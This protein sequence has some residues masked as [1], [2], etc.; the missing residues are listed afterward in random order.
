[1]SGMPAATPLPKT[2]DLASFFPV[3]D[4]PEYRAFKSALAAEIAGVLA[5]A[6]ALDPLPADAAAGEPATAALLR[7]WGGVFAAGEELGSRAA[8]LFCYVGC[9]GAA[10]AADEAVQAEEAA[11][12]LLGAEMGKLG[13]QLLRGL[14][15]AGDAVFARLGAEPA[16]AGAA[17][18]LERLRAEATY[19]MAPAEEALAADLG[20][21]GFRA[22]GRLYDTIS[23]KMTFELAHADGRRETVP[24]AQ[25]RALMAGADRAVRRAAFEGAARTWA[26]AADTCAA[27]LN[28]IAGTRHT[29]Y[30]RRGRRHFL[31]AP[32]HDA[33]VSSGTLDAMFAAVADNY[34]LPRRVLELGARLQG[35]PALAW[36]DL[37]APRPLDPVPTLTWEEGVELVQSAFDAAYPRL[38]NYFRSIVRRR[39]IESEKRPNKR[40]GAFLT[41]SP[42]TL[43]ERIYMTFGGAMHDVVTLA[44]EA[45]HAWHT[46]LLGSLRPCAREYP[47]TLAETAST[48]A[49]KIFIDGLLSRANL[50]DTQRAYLLDTTTNQMPAYLL[51][52]PV[53][54]I[55]ERR[56]YEER[57]AGVVS[58]TRLSELMSAAQREVYGPTL[59]PGGEDPLFWASKLHFSMT[60]ISFYNFP[61]T[62]GFLLS[63]ALF[64]AFGREGP[65]F[66]PRYEAFLLRTGRATC[67]DAVRQTLGW[68]IR[69]AGFWAGAI[70]AGNGSVDAFAAVVSARG[71]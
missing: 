27:V 28:A 55:F 34:A 18:S 41:G 2:W 70:A 63:Q 65:D 47:S 58:P 19:Q 52:I 50:P 40:G 69:D 17:Y 71:R 68:D 60:G 7:E 67:E 16:L 39:W 33:A 25:C 36:Y 43:E 4:G 56:F 64:A 37:E 29:L 35:T 61:Y 32:L 26:A 46:H 42:L 3:F 8:H 22:W 15:P 38:G 57:R 31:D 23:G 11:L 12:E 5:R 9:L 53:R 20:V 1:M 14:R 66:L 24:M 45:G 51:N 6:S 62:F 49:E 21:N 44:H 10:N 54:Y 13:T 30:A 59:E 48:F